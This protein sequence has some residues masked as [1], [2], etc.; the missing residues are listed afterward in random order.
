[1]INNKDLV[2][3]VALFNGE[4]DMEQV[5]GDATTMNLRYTYWY[6][7]NKHDEVDGSITLVEDTN[8]TALQTPRRC[9]GNTKYNITVADYVDTNNLSIEILESNCDNIILQRHALTSGTTSIITNENTSKLYFNIIGDS[10]FATNLGE[11]YGNVSPISSFSDRTCTAFTVN[12]TDITLTILGQQFE[13][14]ISNKTPSD[15]IVTPKYAISDNSIV[16]ITGNTITALK[17][18]TA[19]IFVYV[20]DVYKKINVTVDTSSSIIPIEYRDAVNYFKADGVWQTSSG[21]SGVKGIRIEPNATYSITRNGSYSSWYAA[22]SDELAS[23]VTLSN[24]TELDNTKTETEYTTSS[25]AKYLLVSGANSKMKTLDIEKI[26]G[27]NTDAG[28]N[29]ENTGSGSDEG[30]TGEGDNTGSDNGDSPNDVIDVGKGDEFA[31]HTIKEAESVVQD[32]GVIRIHEGEYEEYTY[33]INKVTSKRKINT[34]V[35]TA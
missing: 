13:I 18:G 23:G 7:N 8:T 31:Y 24:V 20:G 30:G 12:S 28:S 6:A 9:L 26:S 11:L 5:T 33:K 21:E 14:S 17:K 2:C 32:G 27:G 4:E 29:E 3:R 1:M 25:T 10:D 15:S 19:T 22:E 34:C 35:S 16:S